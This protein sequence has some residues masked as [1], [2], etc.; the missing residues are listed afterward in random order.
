MKTVDDYL[1]TLSV[2]DAHL[3]GQMA[4]IVKKTEPS[5]EQ[6]TSYGMPCF[7]YKGKPLISFIVRK[8]HMSLYPFSGKVI[9]GFRAK[10]EGFPISEGSGSIHFSVG[11]PIPEEIL[12]D[13]V[14]ARM[15]EIEGSRPGKG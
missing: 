8:K 13:I 5:V 10:L 3:L 1:A 15:G 9:E 4:E 12:A 7:L 2:E 14:H 11:N 6:G